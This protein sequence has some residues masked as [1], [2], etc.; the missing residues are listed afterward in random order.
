MGVLL[1]MATNLDVSVSL[2]LIIIF[3][4]WVLGLGTY[5][6]L[7]PEIMNLNLG[8]FVA[9]LGGLTIAWIISLMT[10]I[11]A[12]DAAMKRGGDA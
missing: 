11:S 4:I 9:I 10:F 6:V 5:G 8:L 12:Y 1:L 3:S 7:N 2:A